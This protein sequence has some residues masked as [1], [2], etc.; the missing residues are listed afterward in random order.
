M[1][2]FGNGGQSHQSLQM[3]MQGE[4][5]FTY[6]P[7]RVNFILHMGMRHLKK[8]DEAKQIRHNCQDIGKGL[9]GS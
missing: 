4:H 1:L 3:N 9:K 2:D 6:L 5:S 7:L 8:S